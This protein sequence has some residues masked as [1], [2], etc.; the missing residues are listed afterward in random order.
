MSRIV[1]ASAAAFETDDLVLNLERAGLVFTR[2][3]T[4]IGLTQASI[5]CARLLEVVQGRHVFFICTGG[6]IGS[7]PSMRVYSARRVRL[8]PHDIRSGSS[9]LVGDY[10]PTL[11]LDGED[12]GFGHVD[13]AGSLGVSV[14]LEAN[15]RHD[16]MVETIE[17]YGVARAWQHQTK[18]FSAFVTTTNQTGPDARDQWRQNFKTAAQLTAQQLAPKLLSF[19]APKEGFL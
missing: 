11:I 8:C 16:N 18:S 1:I 15:R 6:V 14:R 5:T 9:E 4:G 2:I 7:D 10:D 13:I 19:V 3:V 12:L 17:L